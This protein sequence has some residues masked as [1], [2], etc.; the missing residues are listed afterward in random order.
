M[1]DRLPSPPRGRRAPERTD[2]QRETR[3]PPRSLL[4]AS[5]LTIEAGEEDSVL[6]TV[7]GSISA[8]GPND[9]WSSVEQA[10]EQAN[11]GLVVVDLTRVTGFDVDSIRDLIQIAKAS[12]RRNLDLCALMAGFGNPAPGLWTC[13]HVDRLD[14]AK[15]VIEELGLRDSTI[16]A[17]GR[18]AEIGLTASEIIAR[19][20]TLDDVAARYAKL[21]DTYEAMEPA[22]GDDVLFSYLALV[23]EWRK[24]PAMD[25]QL[26]RDVLPEWIGRRA[27]DTFVS[28]RTSWAPAARE[29]WAEVVQFTAPD[30]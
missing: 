16:T 6:V 24:F 26:P 2:P 1:P 7:A 12:A 13:P 9:L 28:L 5:W 20:W 18:L 29:R 3:T 23:D 30:Q 10:L 27:A 15:A 21:L 22:P 25:P 19:A 4:A 17:V 14:E 11:G 8:D